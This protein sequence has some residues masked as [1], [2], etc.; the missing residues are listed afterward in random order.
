MLVRGEMVLSAL[1][2]VLRVYDIVYDIVLC[3]LKIL[4]NEKKIY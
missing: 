3:E 4:K 1:V 2:G